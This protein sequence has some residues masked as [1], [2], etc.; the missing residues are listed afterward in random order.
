MVKVKNKMRIGLAEVL[1]I[2]ILFIVGYFTVIVLDTGYPL[3][4]SQEYRKIEDVENIV[5]RRWQDNYY[6]RFFWG[7]GTVKVPENLSRNE[8][9]TE[10]IE[11]L[12]DVIGEKNEISQA[13]YSP[14]G[15]YILYC[16]IELGT[17]DIG[18]TDDEHCYYRVYNKNTG[19]V[20]TVYDAY[21][22]WYDLY[23]Q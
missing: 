16:E 20:I 21:R 1:L 10:E 11:V 8:V 15:N 2:F 19:E 18:L 4:F 5:F 23:W 13:I 7:L 17:R 6:R 22:E 12:E 9:G 3:C 14:D